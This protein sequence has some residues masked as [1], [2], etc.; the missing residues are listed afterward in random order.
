MAAVEPT[1]TTVRA[2]DGKALTVERSFARLDAPLAGFSVIEAS[3]IDEV[4]RL[5]GN[6]PCTRGKGTIEIRPIMFIND[7]EWPRRREEK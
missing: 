5:V 2:W 7:G 4:I 3:D 6:T 1:V